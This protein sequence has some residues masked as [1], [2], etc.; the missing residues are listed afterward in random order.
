MLETGRHDEALAEV[1]SLLIGSL[2][3]KLLASQILFAMHEYRRLEPLVQALVASHPEKKE[4]RDLQERW[5]GLREESDKVEQALAARME[6]R[7]GLR[8]APEDLLQRAQLAFQRFDNDA[9]ERD[10]RTVLE[11]A[12]TDLQRASAYRGLGTLRHRLLDFEGAYE[13]LDQARRLAPLRP[14]ILMSLSQTLL[15]LDRMDDAVAVMEFVVRLAPLHRFAHSMLGNGFTKQTYTE[16]EAQNPEAFRRAAEE[17]L[18]GSR[19]Y[20]RR[21]FEQALLHFRRALEFSP[22]YGRAHDGV[23]LVLLLRQ[24]R[25]GKRHEVR[26]RAFAEQ[27]VRG[28]PGLEEFILNWDSLGPDHRRQ[29][30]R[31]LAAWA[32]QIPALQAS[33]ANLYIKRLHELL[34]M[35][36]AQARW[37]DRHTLD[38]RLWDDLDGSGGKNLVSSL[39]SID[40]ARAGWSDILLHEVSHQVHTILPAATRE[41]IERLYSRALE[42][43]EAGEVAFVRRYASTNVNEYFAVAA[44]AL[45]TPQMGRYDR[46]EVVRERQIEIDPE[47]SALMDELFTTHPGRSPR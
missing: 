11:L 38:G 31:S 7:K 37:H 18:R 34:S 15:R 16:L 2:E 28:I 36:P 9:A 39:A 1:A 35:S 42:R 40:F 46:R 20:E 33:G 23:A 47:L 6:K 30:K 21:E 44:V 32:D 25:W 41:E 45:Q 24:L 4:V 19:A 27:S 3:E 14:N 8:P 13:L 29:V 12:R 26:E 5:W 43:Q 22:S 10:W 17:V